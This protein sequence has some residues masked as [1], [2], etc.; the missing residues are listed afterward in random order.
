M[1]HAASGT[2]PSRVHKYLQGKFI[3]TLSLQNA[4]L[5]LVLTTYII[6]LHKRVTKFIGEFVEGF[7]RHLLSL[8]KCDRERSFSSYGNF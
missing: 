3:T 4:P 8:D 6:G 5:S 7:H 2:R 1:T